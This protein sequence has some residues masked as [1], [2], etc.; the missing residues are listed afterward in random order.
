MKIHTTQIAK[1]GTASYI[2][3]MNAATNQVAYTIDTSSSLASV[4]G[5][6]R[7][8]LDVS[9]ANLPQGSYYVAMDASAVQSTGGVA[10]DAVTDQNFWTFSIGLRCFCVVKKIGHKIMSF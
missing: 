9:Q 7:L 2:K 5:G 3:I 4:S 6:K 10:S 8:T 1:P